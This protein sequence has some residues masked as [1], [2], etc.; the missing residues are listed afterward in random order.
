MKKIS[1]HFGYSLIELMVTMLIGFI[2]LNGVFQV[3]FSSKRSQIDHTEISYI[4]ENA[5]FAID[6]LSRDIRM[7]GYLGCASKTDQVNVI[8]QDVMGSLDSA[9]IS[10]F[11][12]NK[13]NTHFPAEYQ[14]QVKSNT[15]SLI[16]RRGES[17]QEY[18]VRDQNPNAKTI[19]LWANHSF[20][21]NQPLALVDGSCQFSALFTANKINGPNKISHEAAGLNC[22]D[23]LRGR[24]SCTDCSGTNCPNTLVN[25]AYLA[26]SRIMPLVANAYFIGDSTLLPGTPALKRQSMVVVSGALT[27]RTEE[28]ATGVEN[29]QFTYGVDTN[30]SGVINEYRKAS[31]MDIND[32]GNIDNSDWE[33]VRSVKVDMLLI[34]QSPVFQQPQTVSFNGVDYP[35][36]FMRQVVSTTIQI[37][38]QS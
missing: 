6:T 34:S 36:L 17:E 13:D 20:E 8:S 26:G 28:L 11:E 7:A 25:Q 4:Q 29:I 18:L 32:D 37:R 30:N 1:N 21:A 16:I 5:R 9:S 31:E 35:G 19:T 2:I 24:Y 12:G 15:D 3:V 23:V 27:T 33:F 38:N 14:A 22:N 10:G